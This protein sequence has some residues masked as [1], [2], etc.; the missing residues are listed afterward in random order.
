MF[1]VCVLSNNVRL[2]R[3]RP[4]RKE[5][6]VS[7]SL[8]LGFPQV[9]TTEGEIAQNIWLRAGGKGML[10]LFFKSIQK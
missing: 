6:L 7:T 4:G 5:E 9:S 8:G 1:C 3:Y 10:Q 2:S